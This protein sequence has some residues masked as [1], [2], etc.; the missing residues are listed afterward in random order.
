MFKKFKAD[1]NVNNA[2]LLKNSVQRAIQ[3]QIV[4]TYP[5]LT[6]VIDEIIPK[7]SMMTAK[8]LDNEVQLLII[9]NEILFF[10]IKNDPNFYP[11]LR[12]VHKYPNMIPKLQVDRGAIRFVLGGAHI[13]CPGFTSA[14]G[15]LP[16]NNPDL[17]EDDLKVT[18]EAGSPVA[19]YGE[20]KE[21]AMAIGVLKMSIEDIKKIN[22]GIAVENHHFLMDG[23][24]QDGK[25]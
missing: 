14:G 7:K 24:W 3:N 2:S 9:N 6:E 4:E 21:H 20:G 12:L 11:T 22:K 18:L 8:A 10:Q 17:G 5:A 15:F 16:E 13:M 23:L 19:I 1:E 25:I